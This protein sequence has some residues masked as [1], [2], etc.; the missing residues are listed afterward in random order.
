MTSQA[1]NRSR[2]PTRTT[3]TGKRRSR[4]H[5]GCTVSLFASMVT[6]GHRRLVSRRCRMSFR[7][8]SASSSSSR[9]RAAR[10]A[11]RWA[12]LPTAACCGRTPRSYQPSVHHALPAVRK[13]PASPSNKHEHPATSAVLSPQF[14]VTMRWHAGF[15][16]VPMT[17]ATLVRRVLEG[18]TAAFTTARGPARRGMHAVR[19]AD[20]RQPRGRRGRDAGELSPSVSVARALRGTTGLS[21]VAVPDSRE[22]MPHRG[23]STTAPSPYVPRGRQRDRVGQ[24]ATG[25]RLHRAARGVA[26]CHR[27][28]RPRPARGVSL[29]ARRA[30]QLR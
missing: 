28:T 14:L 1:G 30:A 7:G 23:R 5:P 20:A 16:S 11:A 3:I 9:R 17:D 27:R 2:S 25:R 4:S 19:N 29:E 10:I 18:D 21:N 6:R 26:A 15:N 8:Q 24:R 22:S 13:H 12:H